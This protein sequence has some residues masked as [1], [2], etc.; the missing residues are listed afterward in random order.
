MFYVVCVLFV[1]SNVCSYAAGRR[2][3]KGNNGTAEGNQSAGSAEI[4]GIGNEVGAIGIE[5]ASSQST[6]EGLQHTN[7]SAG[8]LI[9]E[10][11]DIL[12]GNN[13]GNNRHNGRI[14]D[15]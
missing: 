11:E 9:A 13:R 1:V 10:M 12:N 2:K 3:A 15:L 5:I 7:A 4:A 14:S 8:T 6:V